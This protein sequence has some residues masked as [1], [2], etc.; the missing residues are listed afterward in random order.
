MAAKE[1]AEYKYG[2]ETGNTKVILSL[3]A[4]ILAIGIVIAAIIINP[5][6]IALIP[7]P[8]IIVII[9]KRTPSSNLIFIGERY[10]IIGT[11]V[12]YYKNIEKTSLDKKIEKFT[13]TAIEGK[14]YEINAASFPTNARKPDKIKKNKTAKFEK[15]VDKILARLKEISPGSIK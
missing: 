5:L 12:I 9:N 10:L 11:N 6:A 3:T 2:N 7:I 8:I 13:L 1:F 4:G 14:T 15:A